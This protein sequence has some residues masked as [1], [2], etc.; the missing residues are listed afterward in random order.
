MK[1]YLTLL[2]R[3]AEQV[4]APRKNRTNQENGDDFEFW[5]CD[6]LISKLNYQI[7]DCSPNRTLLKLKNKNTRYCTLRDVFP[8]KV[9]KDIRIK[10][11]DVKRLTYDIKSDKKFVV[12][13]P[14]PGCSPDI[15]IVSNKNLIPIECKTSWRG[16][17]NFNDTI[18]KDGY[19]FMFANLG[20]QTVRH[21]S[22]LDL[23]HPFKDEYLIKIHQKY[24]LNGEKIF[25]DALRK[26]WFSFDGIQVK[27]AHRGRHQ[28]RLSREIQ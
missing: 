3:I 8:E 20:R 12:Y 17:Y 15:L 5:V 24:V 26:R 13:Q 25:K 23:E 2:N 10:L 7:I 19:R 21:T 1:K 22:G 4:Y 11:N 27:Y 18:P 28:F 14:W 6:Q 9:I 16:T